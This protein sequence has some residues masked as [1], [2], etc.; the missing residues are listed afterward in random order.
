MWETGRYIRPVDPVLLYNQPGRPRWEVSEQDV[1]IQPP[2][3]ETE[4][5]RIEG[6][7]KAKGHSRQQ[8]KGVIGRVMLSSK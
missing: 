1:A 3:G 7:V 6:H 8:I 5:L 2:L 4:T